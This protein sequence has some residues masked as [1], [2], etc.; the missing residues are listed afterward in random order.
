[1]NE[2]TFNLSSVTR[3][4]IAI[5]RRSF[6]EIM[7]T[8]ILGFSLYISVS[9][10]LAAINFFAIGGGKLVAIPVSLITGVFLIIL[11][12]IIQQAISRVLLKGVSLQVAFSSSFLDW[13]PIAVTYFFCIA[14]ILGGATLL[15]IPGIIFSILFSF[16]S[17]VLADTG[18]S[19]IDS[20]MISK[21][22]VSG[23]WWKTLGYFFLAGLFAFLAVIIPVAGFYIHPLAGIITIIPAIGF[24]FTFP[25]AFIVSF[26]KA[27]S[28][29]RAE[30]RSAPITT[31]HWFQKV[32]LGVGIVIF[33]IAA[34]LSVLSEDKKTGTP[35]SS[36]PEF[37][38]EFKR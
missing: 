15:I 13:R 32:A 14:A 24:I 6:W 21:A 7:G 5:V 23:S 1:M 19:G 26:Y 28:A 4:A 38:L 35:R 29:S 10:N 34:V 27:L 8:I 3:D 20:L 25:P 11:Q 18:K 9:I 31:P 12:F 33:V 16:A 36:F 30:V 2:N 37:P 22:Y 17:L